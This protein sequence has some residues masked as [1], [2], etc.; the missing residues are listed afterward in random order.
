M[1]VVHGTDKLLTA[2]KKMKGVEGR[3]L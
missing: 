3:R 1:R 2:A